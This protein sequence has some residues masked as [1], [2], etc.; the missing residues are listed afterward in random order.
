MQYKNLTLIGTSH[1]AKQSLKEIEDAFEREKPDII[2][3]ELDAKRLP[4]LMSNSH[5]K[6]GLRDMMRIGLKGYLFATIGGYAQRKLGAMV[7]M[8]PGSEMK[9]AVK[10]AQKNHLRL[11]LIDRDIDITLQRFSKSLTWREKFRFIGDIFKSFFQRKKAMEEL[12][13]TS[14]DLSKVPEKELIRKLMKQLEKRYPNIYKTLVKERNNV[15]ATNLYKM[16]LAEPEKKVLAVVG[17][18]HEEEMIEMIKK[19]FTGKID[20]VI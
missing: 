12:G 17:A 10:L 6:P 9:L 14:F 8:T 16:M 5:R 18:G 20:V 2:A 7:G 1:I 15:M 3:V 4:A 11:A 19:R 13:M